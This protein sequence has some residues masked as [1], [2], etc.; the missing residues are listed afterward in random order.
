MPT[1]LIFTLRP[2]REAVVP[3]NLGRATHA[4]ILR[5]IAKD[6]PELAE[7]IHENDGPKPLTVSNVHGLRRRGASAQVSTST[8]YHLRTTLLSSRLEELAQSWQPTTIQALDLD[9]MPWIVE[10]VITAPAD[11]SWA[12]RTTYDR[13]VAMSQLYDFNNPY[14]WTFEFASPVTFRQHGINQPLPTPDLVFGSLLDKWNVF[15]AK[16]LPNDIRRL[17]GE[18][19]AISRFEL[20]SV[21]ETTK[22]GALQIGTIGRCTYTMTKRDHHLTPYIDTLARF[23][24]YSGI[25]AGTTRGFG[26]VRLLELSTTPPPKGFQRTRQIGGD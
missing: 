24:F 3:S 14:R 6:D 17:I 23:A 26:Q 4:A 8:T 18:R 9:G 25:G 1:A 20:S 22:N 11:N 13:I 15:A 16:P 2:D 19:L 21:A 10:Q 12:D 5:L 7:N